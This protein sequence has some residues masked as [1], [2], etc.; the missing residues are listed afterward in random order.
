MEH[1]A[2]L[3]DFLDGSIGLPDIA[4]RHGLTLSQLV[5]VMSS[6]E[7]DALLIDVETLVERRLKIAQVKAHRTAVATLAALD[8]AEAAGCPSPGPVASPVLRRQPYSGVFH[9]QSHPPTPHRPAPG[10]TPRH[11]REPRLLPRPEEE[12]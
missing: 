4:S 7:F 9:P 1:D 8:A 3:R 5:E 6:R 10:R 12:S 2:L 11:A